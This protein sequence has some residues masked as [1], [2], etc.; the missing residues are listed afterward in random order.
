L[1]TAGLYVDLGYRRFGLYVDKLAD[2]TGMTRANLYNWVYIGEAFTKYRSD[3]DKI[4]FSENDGPTK[5]PFLDRALE[6]HQKREVFRAV[7][8]MSY[9]AF[10]EWARGKNESIPAEPAYK[11]VG[12]KGSTVYAGRRPLLSIADDVAPED[13]KYYEKVLL[14]AAEARELDEVA[15]VFRFYDER[16][17]RI[18]DKIYNRELKSI[19]SKK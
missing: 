13:R 9:R 8:D 3:L 10:Q 19:R 5:L 18:F 4:G 16:E 6:N 12:I 7:K 17:A 11:A 2:D 14:E 15:R 1:Q